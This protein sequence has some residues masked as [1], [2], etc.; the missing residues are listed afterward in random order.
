MAAHFTWIKS[1]LNLI[2]QALENTLQDD[3]A[4][5]RHQAARCLDVIANGI[6]TYLVKQSNQSDFESDIDV[7]LEFWSKML[8]II[9]QQL[10][11]LDQRRQTRWTFCDAYS[12]IGVHVYERLAVS[13]C[14]IA[15]YHWNCS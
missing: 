7:A 3:V 6:S 10:N 2:A 14:I 1:H 12:N 11:D 9:S 8:P 5:V 4:T 13:F 15:L